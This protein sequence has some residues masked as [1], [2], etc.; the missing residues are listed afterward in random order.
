MF[1]F[2][3]T[4]DSLGRNAQHKQLELKL[5][6]VQHFFSEFFSTRGCKGGSKVDGI[7][8]SIG[9]FFSLFHH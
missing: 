2:H 5:I 4:C 1:N 6:L 3:F 9:F 8:N 7:V